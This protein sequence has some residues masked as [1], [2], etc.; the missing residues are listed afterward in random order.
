MKA[1]NLQR[2][3]AHGLPVPPFIVVTK[4]TPLRPDFSE[5]ERFAVRS[6]FEAEDSAALSFAGQFETLLNVEREDLPEAVRRV[7]QSYESGYAAYA[8]AHGLPE[9]DA[10]A[11]A[12]VLV[13][14]MVD[15]EF[16]GVLFT[17]NPTG[18]LNEIVIVVGAGLGS[19]V[20][21]DRADT[22]TYY[23][24]KDDAVYYYEQSGDAPLLPPE[25]LQ[26]LIELGLEVECLFSAPT[27]VEY[28]VQGGKVWLL[29]ARPI[30]TLSGGETI[31]LDNSNIVESYPDLTLP[32]SQSFVKEIYYRIFKSLLLEV[33]HKSPIVE[34][35][36]GEI[37]D[38]VDMANGR[39]YYRISSWYGVLRLMPFSHFFIR[40]W[41]QMLGVENKTVT[42]TE[43]R[44][45]WRVKA[46]LGWE[47]ARCVL[48]T[49]KRMD[50]LGAF[51]D[52]YAAELDGRL[53]AILADETHEQMPRLLA[54]YH[55]MLDDIL[56]RWHVTLINDM[57]AFLFT[58]LAGKRSKAALADIR[59]LES[60]KPV[61]RILALVDIARAHG[62]DSK[63]YRAAKAD[64]IDE[65]GD[66]CLGELKLETH[67]YRTHPA[68]VDD[69]VRARLDAP[70]RLNTA[71]AQQ[72]TGRDS[73]LVRRAKLGIYNRERSRMNRTRIFG[74]IRFIFRAIGE[75]LCREGRID[76]PED[77]FY[78]S[79]PELEAPG[80]GDLRE[81]VLQ[82]KAEF[83]MYA[84]LPAYSRLIF[85]SAIRSK[86]VQHASFDQLR[87]DD[88]LTGVSAA[89]GR[90]TGEALVVTNPDLSLD[91][92][93]KILITR[94]TDPGWVFLIENAAGI[95]AEKGSLL[96]HTAIITRELHKP[97]MV[98]V[99]DACKRIRTGDL[100]ELDSTAGTIRILNRTD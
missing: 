73:F 43:R 95:I 52:A 25:A 87:H 30:T 60:M 97:S 27:D 13:Q 83:A 21:E 80:K 46:T 7:R 100:V 42:A 33:T 1:E 64:F 81:T 9:A 14:E 20:V 45:P 71:G 24:N 34:D 41:Q 48:Q 40:V 17:A 70:T 65:Y 22:T 91:T 12:P 79:V 54:V 66:R 85:D 61:Q 89:L 32:L 82:R 16:A 15:A 39:V 51:Y 3:R 63:A 23:Y 84:E 75:E 59:N 72:K 29:Q 19:A 28:A 58:Y 92:R 53:K 38:M 94:S 31:V 36:D 74:T 26:R 44:V 77:V 11:D 5:A 47:L 98:N 55:D 56:A 6:T 2:M 8:K 93:G 86:R 57:Y 96:S 69:F 37:R 35:L 18:Q 99:R 50:A 76:D 49:P 67:T 78:I 10:S 4:D 90:V 88:T 68:L 62:M